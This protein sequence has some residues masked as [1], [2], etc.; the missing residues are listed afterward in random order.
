MSSRVRNMGAGLACSS[1]YSVNPNLNCGGGDKKQG[2][3]PYT[4]TSTPWAMNAMLIRANGSTK[5]RSTIFTLNQLGGVSSS[6]F[7][8]YS[9]NYARARGVHRVPPFFLALHPTYI[10]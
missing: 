6:S 8:S 7:S 2:L 5:G 3:P 1:N 4:N 10:N 9:N